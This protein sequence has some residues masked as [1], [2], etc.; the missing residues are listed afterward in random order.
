MDCQRLVSTGAA[1]ESTLAVGMCTCLPL[2]ARAAA[3]TTSAEDRY[4]FFVCLQEE[5]LGNHPWSLFPVLVSKKEQHNMTRSKKQSALPEG[6]ALVET[7]DGRWFDA[8]AS[9]PEIP[10]RIDIMEGPALIPPALDIFHHPEPGH[11]CREEEIETCRA[12][13]EAVEL[14][15]YW[16]RLAACTELYPERTAWYLDE[17]VQLARDDTL[18]LHCGISVYAMVLARQTTGNEVIAATGNT[19]DEAIETLYQR[20][21]QWSCEHHD[22]TCES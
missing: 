8:C 14:T 11:D 21:Y 5:R 15:E 20:V 18:R 19:P 17:I 1:V 22:T 2:S 13:C 10:H 9:L 3:R 6:M 4:V 12:W 7:A 16:Q